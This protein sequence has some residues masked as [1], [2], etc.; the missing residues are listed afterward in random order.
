[1]KKQYITPTIK[2]TEE[3]TECFICTSIISGMEGTGSLSTTVSNEETSDYLSRG[4]RN[5]WDDED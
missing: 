1:M 5:V 2:V 4:S 3:T